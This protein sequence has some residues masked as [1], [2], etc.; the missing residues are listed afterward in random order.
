MSVDGNDIKTVWLFLPFLFLE[1]NNYDIQRAKG[2]NT[3]VIVM[4]ANSNLQ[5]FFS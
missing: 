3:Q 4:K 5:I 2:K 1:R